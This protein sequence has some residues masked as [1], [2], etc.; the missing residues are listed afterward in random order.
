MIL[1]CVAERP[2]HRL[3]LHDYGKFHSEACRDIN[4]IAHLEAVEPP[5]NLRASV[6]Q[7]LVAVVDIHRHLHHLLVI[8]AV[9]IAADAA[10]LAVIQADLS[11]IGDEI[12][13]LPNLY[14]PLKAVIIKLIAAGVIVEERGGIAE[15]IIEQAEAEVTHPNIDG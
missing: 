3:I 10:G 13:A 14:H 1:Y 15:N 2:D 5:V 11:A 8:G 4:G 9:I 12:I 7:Q 6:K